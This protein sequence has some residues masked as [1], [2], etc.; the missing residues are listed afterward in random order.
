MRKQLAEGTLHVF[1]TSKFTVNGQHIS[2]FLADIDGDYVGETE[3]CFD[4]IIKESF[5]RSAPY[6]DLK[7]DGITLLNEKI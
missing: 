7:I 2:S 3:V 1:D 5:L 4:G 6:F